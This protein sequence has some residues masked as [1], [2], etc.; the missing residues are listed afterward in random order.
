MDILR[1]R[2]SGKVRVLSFSKVAYA[3]ERALAACAELRPLGEQWQKKQ[4]G[5]GLHVFLGARKSFKCKK[6][7]GSGESGVAALSLSVGGGGSVF[8]VW[9]PMFQVH[10]SLW[11]GR[12]CLRRQP[13]AGSER[14]SRC[15]DSVLLQL[16]P[17]GRPRRGSPCVFYCR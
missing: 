16:D 11:S 1:I 3:E 17:R 2:I 8:G 13:D 9:A 7:T 4:P 14:P 10:Q 15:E 5:C 6:L 12:G